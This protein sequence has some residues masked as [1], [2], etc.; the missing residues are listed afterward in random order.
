MNRR[1]P[2]KTAL[3]L[4]A[5]FTLLCGI[6]FPGLVY[7]ASQ[8]LFPYQAG[9]SLLE[10]NGKVVGSQWIGQ[11]FK[12]KRYFW[13]R[14]SAT[15]PHPYDASSSSGSNFSTKN[16]SLKKL[17]LERQQSLLLAHP[18]RTNIPADLLFAS[19]SGLDPEISPEAARFQALRVATA[20]GLQEE[21]VL[22]LIDATT[23]ERQLQVMGERRVNV[24]RLNL[25]LDAIR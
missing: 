4:L 22:K 16:P 23:A 24:L 25:A 11:E 2:M 18:G 10:V 7:V 9:G 1:A 17:L 15:S 8:I 5:S 20:R 14:P 19:G 6:V 21:Q 13:G 12:E 3:L